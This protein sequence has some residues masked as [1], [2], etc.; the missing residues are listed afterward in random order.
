MNKEKL[1]ETYAT[2]KVGNLEMNVY[3]PY[4]AIPYHWH[5]E[6]EM[7]YVTHGQCKCIINGETITVNENDALLVQG[8]ELHTVVLDTASKCYAIVFH[9]HL[10][11]SD[12]IKF[13]S[14][15]INFKRIFSHKNACEKKILTNISSMMMCVSYMKK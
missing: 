7:I 8:G 11:G 1:K 4:C 15:D 14:G 5:D 12:C 10:C 2:H 6:L 3:V 9:P 13:F